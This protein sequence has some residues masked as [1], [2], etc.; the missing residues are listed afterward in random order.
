MPHW[1]IRPHKDTEFDECWLPAESDSDHH[2]A[3]EYA[4]EVLEQLWDQMR[5]GDG[6]ATVTIELASGDMP[7]DD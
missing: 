1:I 4:K 6:P 2:A 7:S 3:H 5:E